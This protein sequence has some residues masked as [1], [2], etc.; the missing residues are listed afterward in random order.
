MQVP[1]L[2][3]K[4]PYEELKDELDAAYARFMTSGWYVLGTET[5][6]F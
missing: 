3:M 5:Q 1:L 6:A 2:D 4:A